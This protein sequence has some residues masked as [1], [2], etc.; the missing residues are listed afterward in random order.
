MIVASFLWVINVKNIDGRG[1]SVIYNQSN[2]LLTIINIV[3]TRTKLCLGTETTDFEFC[4]FKISVTNF[5]FQPY[6]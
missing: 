2:V 3:Q 5:T 1:I 4:N 6:E